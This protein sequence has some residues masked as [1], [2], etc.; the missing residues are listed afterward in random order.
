VA[1]AGGVVNG[2]IVNSD[3]GGRA[4]GMASISVQLASLTLA[5]GKT[6][7]INEVFGL[8]YLISYGNQT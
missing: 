3:P 8:F 1:T 7:I 2:T 4:K 6:V 5:N